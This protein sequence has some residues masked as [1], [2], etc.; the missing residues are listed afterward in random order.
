MTEN[1][2]PTL[3]AAIL[4]GEAGPWCDDVLTPQNEDC[5]AIAGEALTDALKGLTESQG[6]DMAKWRW[7][8]VH[9]TQFPHNPFS[10]VDMLKRFFHRSIETGGD[11]FTVNPSPYKLGGDFSSNWVPSYRQ[12]ID[13][14]DWD[15]SRFMHTTGQSGNVLSSHY[16]DLIQSWRNVEYVPM[17]WSRE[18]AQQQ[19]KETLRLQP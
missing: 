14:S 15:N 12:I 10:Q 18:K 5:P 6:K 3:V 19:A 1:H 11:N 4:R 7:G 17:L 16:D 9:Q 8:D 2:R 13:L